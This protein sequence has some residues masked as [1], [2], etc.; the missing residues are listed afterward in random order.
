MC[1]SPSD[2]D[3][4]AAPKRP[5]LASIC[6]YLAR[7]RTT[8]TSKSR[9][10]R[11][12][13]PGKLFR[14]RGQGINVDRVQFVKQA[15]RS[16]ES[17]PTMRI[18]TPSTSHQSKPVA[19]HLEQAVTSPHRVSRS[20]QTQL[21]SGYDVVHAPDSPKRRASQQIFVTPSRSPTSLRSSSSSQGALALPPRRS[22][23]RWSPG[24]GGWKF[25]FVRLRAEDAIILERLTHQLETGSFQQR[26]RMLSFLHQ[27]VLEDFPPEAILQV[28]WLHI[29]MAPPTS[30]CTRS[31]TPMIF[32]FCL[33]FMCHLA[34]AYVPYDLLC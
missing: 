5:R 27:H 12:A 26:V 22:S 18:S 15:V 21:L 33:Q 19:E 3:V 14:S 29:N 28:R 32:A 25:P 31:T 34:Y 23:R 30:T 6:R 4:C 13:R 9:L 17:K 2:V 20:R 24:L 8:C 10:R 16:D 11:S 7:T 1:D